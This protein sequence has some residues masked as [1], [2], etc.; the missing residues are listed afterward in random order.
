MSKNLVVLTIEYPEP[1]LGKEIPYLSKAF[2]KVHVIYGVS[3]SKD[4]SIPQF[5]NV[6]TIQLFI[7]PDFS[8]PLKL[9]F[10][11]FR[12]VLGVYLYTLLKRGNLWPY[13]K[14][15]KSFIGY[16]LI[17]AD[18]IRPLRQYISK[19]KLK[20]A[21]FYDY[22]LVDSTLALAALKKRGLVGKTVARAHGFDLY[23]DRQF[24]SRVPFI[25]YRIAHLD[26]VFTICRH[27]QDYLKRRVPPSLNKKVDLSYLGIST[28]FVTEP[29]R[30]G[31]G[32][33]TVVSCASM[34][35]VKR[36]D[37]IIETLKLVSI[38]I[39]WIHF[40]DGPLRESLEKVSLELPSNV[41]TSFKG[42]V[43][44]AKV[45][46]F[47]SLNYVDL[48]ISLSESEGLPV[49]MMEAISF[50]IPI[51]ATSVNG[52][53]EIVTE[54][55]GVL[56]DKST[57]VTEVCKVLHEVLRGYNFNRNEIRNFFQSRFDARQNYESF[58]KKL[59][60]VK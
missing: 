10:R 24:E 12:F 19:N 45:L 38:G 29:I 44:N 25:E 59:I 4:E 18:K 7:S 49:S 28:A 35:P 56:V 17:E 20:D 33:Y 31:L 36:I 42:N 48:F 53:P 26:K 47:Y 39:T 34:I 55:T 6:E 52:I 54:K 13:L 30:N 1:L 27:G 22:W 15:Y 43:P 58:I 51:L 46:E 50:G 3:S 5:N 8:K 23:D 2:D 57:N 32:N 60:E 14:H 16:L 21:I 41:K 37:K 9:L 40:G 11:H